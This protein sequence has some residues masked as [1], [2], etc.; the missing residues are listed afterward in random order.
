MSGTF[1]VPDGARVWILMRMWTGLINREK[2]LLKLKIPA[3]LKLLHQVC[4]RRGIVLSRGK[5]ICSLHMPLCAQGAKR[6]PVPCRR[7]WE[8]VT[9]FGG[10]CFP[11]SISLTWATDKLFL[12]ADTEPEFPF[13]MVTLKAAQDSLSSGM[14]WGD[15]VVLCLS[16]QEAG[17]LMSCSPTKTAWGNK[18]SDSPWKLLQTS[19]ESSQ[20]IKLIGRHQK[21]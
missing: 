13:F 11:Q 5:R 6:T 8:G 17:V 21:D 10:L 1:G 19:S 2:P 7:E 16:S 18:I 3:S 12:A 20:V 9:Q 14:K 4:Q 15:C